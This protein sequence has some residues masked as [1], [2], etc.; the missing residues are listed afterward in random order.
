VGFDRALGV[1]SSLLDAATAT[2]PGLV[3]QWALVAIFLTSGIAKV[4]R[5]G[6]AAVAI[7][8]FGLTRSVRRSY[9]SAAGVFE[10]ALAVCLGITAFPA[11]SNAA[12]ALVLAVTAALLALFAILIAGSL[13]RGDRFPCACFGDGSEEISRR[14]LART[15]AIGLVS[16]PPLVASL[17]SAEG[18]P[19]RDSLLAGVVGVG[20]LSTAVLVAAGTRLLRAGT[21]E[22]VA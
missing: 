9:G 18:F 19:S 22:E 11:A 1:V 8:N 13:R 10:I 4:R 21:R 5:P 15:L 6:H 7:S 16:L 12:R 17:A 20:A 3:A 14:S 2:T